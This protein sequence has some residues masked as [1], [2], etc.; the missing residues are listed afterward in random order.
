MYQHFGRVSITRLKQMSRKVLLEGLPENIPELEEPCPICLLT[1]ATKICRSSITDVSKTFPGFMLQIYFSFFNAESICGL[2]S[3]F[4]AICSANL[5]PFGFPSRSKSPHLDII[6][7]LVTLL[8]NQ[9]KK[10]SFI[11]LE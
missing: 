5:Y 8:R 6:K 1:K 7:F 9:D 4:V 11:E 2:T 3:T 10:V